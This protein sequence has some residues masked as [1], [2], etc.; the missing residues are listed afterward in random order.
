MVCSTDMI[1]A[2]SNS[3]K[4]PLLQ[5]PGEIRTKIWKY[6]LG[7]HKIDFSHRSQGQSVQPT[8]DIRPLRTATYFPRP[9]VRPSFALPQVCRQIYV[10]SSPFIYTLNTF[11]FNGSRSFDRWF[12]DRPLG[13]KRLVASVNVTADYAKIYLGGLRSAFSQKLPNIK[14]VGVSEHIA[15]YYMYPPGAGVEMTKENITRQIRSRE[16]AGLE[17]EWVPSWSF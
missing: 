14:R 1:S 8:L 17:V 12:K 7:Y 11:S 16:I 5:L 15:R 3:F 13:Q 6:S 9:F 2:K 10:E 4:S